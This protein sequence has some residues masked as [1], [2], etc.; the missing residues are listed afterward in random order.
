MRSYI[1]T[2]F[3]E[4]LKG[5]KLI[6]LRTGKINH[7]VLLYVFFFP[8]LKLNALPHQSVMFQLTL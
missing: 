6:M 2:S 1:H 8:K 5:Y 7:C 4:K 3:V